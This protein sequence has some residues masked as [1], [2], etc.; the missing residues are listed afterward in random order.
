MESMGLKTCIVPGCE[1]IPEPKAREIWAEAERKGVTIFE[2]R[3]LAHC[4]D[5]FV[6]A[7][8]AKI[9]QDKLTPKPYQPGL[10]E[11]KG[12]SN[13]TTDPICHREAMSRTE[14]AKIFGIDVPQVNRFV[15]EGLLEHTEPGPDRR[16]DRIQKSSVRA[17]AQL[18][19][20]GGEFLNSI[21]EQARTPITRRRGRLK[22]LLNTGALD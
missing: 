12:R 8:I 6:R 19:V 18:I 20:T 7:K 16:R 17:L 9:E 14:A 13:E 21:P 2:G 22:L 4:R 1:V 10:G 5:A 15:S 3:C 11:K